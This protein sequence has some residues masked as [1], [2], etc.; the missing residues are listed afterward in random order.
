ML[1]IVGISVCVCLKALDYN[2]ARYFTMNRPREMKQEEWLKFANHQL[3]TVK[4]HHFIYLQVTDE[5]PWKS[6]AS[7]VWSEL[8]LL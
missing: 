5:Q 7:G 2:T 8:K 6:S 3:L 4:N 1:E